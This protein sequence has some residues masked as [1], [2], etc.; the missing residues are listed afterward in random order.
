MAINIQNLIDVVNAKLTAADSATPAQELIKLYQVKNDIDASVG[1]L[2]YGSL[3]S[4][5][6]A[7]GANAG[8]I[9]FIDDTKYDKY[10]TFY[11]SN[12]SEWTRLNLTTD[13]DEDQLIF[14]HA[15]PGNIYGYA[16]GGFELA[17]TSYIDRYAFASDGNAVL[18]G[19]LTLARESSSGQKS[20]TYGYT[21]GG[22]TPSSN[23]TID[24]FEF[25]NETNATDV[26]DLVANLHRMA[27]HSSQTNGYVSGGRSNTAI[28]KWPFSTDT[29]ATS[30]GTL[31]YNLDYVAGISTFDYNSAYTTGGFPAAANYIQKFPFSNESLGIDVGDLYVVRYWHSSQSGFQYGYSFGSATTD[32]TIIEKFPYAVETTSI[33][34][35]DL[36]SGI[37]E[38]NGSSSREN[39]YSTGGSAPA[40]INVIQKWP[41]AVD[42][43]ATDVG[44]LTSIRTSP[45][46]NQ[47]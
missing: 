44:D 9:V 46:G 25:L 22:V 19:N 16:A 13:S 4:L 2:S 28:Q 3:K 12:G 39:V 29:N 17:V 31:T 23:N 27:G 47:V 36:L 43:N 33:Y 34:V 8:E 14:S 42:Q 21:A 35:G 11:F 1:V 45:A 40:V 7:S 26:G 32:N 20:S 30:V 15:F 41:Y 6:T 10:G 5:P 37:S 38:P 18:V 24:K